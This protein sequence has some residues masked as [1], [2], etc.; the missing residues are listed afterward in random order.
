MAQAHLNVSGAGMFMH[1]KGAM[2]SM[3]CLASDSAPGC[4][5]D[6][7]DAWP[8]VAG[9]KVDKPARAQLGKLS[10][11]RVQGQAC[12]P[13]G[14]TWMPLGVSSPAIKTPSHSAPA[15]SAG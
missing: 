2:K 4:C 7:S 14:S 13:A 10:G 5:D 3:A 1:A 12:P 6:G 9:V 8:A 15:Q 11:H